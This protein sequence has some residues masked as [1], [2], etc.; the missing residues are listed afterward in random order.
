MLFRPI[1]T[2]VDYLEHAENAEQFL[3][4]LGS[5]LYVR[6]RWFCSSICLVMVS[7]H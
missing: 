3:C 5:L 7:V 2:S 6:W 4:S 1:A